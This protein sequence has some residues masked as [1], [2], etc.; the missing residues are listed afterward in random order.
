MPVKVMNHYQPAL[1]K[2]HALRK[3]NFCARLPIKNNLKL[4]SAR[5]ASEENLEDFDNLSA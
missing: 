4:A 1:G 2:N 5:G 3:S